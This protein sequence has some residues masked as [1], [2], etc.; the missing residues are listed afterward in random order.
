MMD[1]NKI[2]YSQPLCNVPYLQHLPMEVHG[3]NL[4]NE[5]PSYLIQDSLE[6]LNM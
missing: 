3:D 1:N 2:S 6:V 5:V 4:S